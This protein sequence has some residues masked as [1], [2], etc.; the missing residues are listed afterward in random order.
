MYVSLTLM[1]FVLLKKIINLKYESDVSM[2]TI[3]YYFDMW[4]KLV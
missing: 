1:F 3:S 2:L 4:D